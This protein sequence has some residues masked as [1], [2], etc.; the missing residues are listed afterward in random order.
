MR[1]LTRLFTRH[2]LHFVTTIL[3]TDNRVTLL[4]LVRKQNVKHDLGFIVESEESF[5]QG[6]NGLA[7]TDIIKLQEEM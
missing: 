7:R 3:L 4:V 6:M 1:R 5:S 2:N